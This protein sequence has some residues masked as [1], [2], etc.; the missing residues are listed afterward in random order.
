[1]TTMPSSLGPSTAAKAMNSQKKK[2][3]QQQQQQFVMAVPFF[4]E[5]PNNPDANQQHNAKA[6]FEVPFAVA[7]QLVKQ[8]ILCRGSCFYLSV[9]VVSSDQ[10]TA[11]ICTYFYT[12]QDPQV[13][14]LEIAKRLSNRI[15]DPNASQ[16]LSSM[17]FGG[18]RGK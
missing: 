15:G 16:A 1:M 18:Q 9:D 7:H 3:Q 12:A 14:A 4:V 8:P 13:T 5:T 17:V 10:N 2:Q 11:Y 6:I